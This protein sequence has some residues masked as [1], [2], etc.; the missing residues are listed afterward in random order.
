ML[1][2]NDQ[3][4]VVTAPPEVQPA[5]DDTL[6]IVGWTRWWHWLIVV[7]LFTA[8]FLYY[9]VWRFDQRWRQL[10]VGDSADRMKELLG[11]LPNPSYSVQTASGGTEAY[12]YTKYWK[13]YEVVVSPSTQRVTRKTELRN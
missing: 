6:E 13:S 3:G 10:Q 9:P 8:A 5:N 12:V 7:A 11:Y 4:D 2:V 1:N